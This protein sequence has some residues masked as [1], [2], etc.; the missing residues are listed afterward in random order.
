MTVFRW[1]LLRHPVDPAFR[2]MAFPAHRHL[3]D[4]RTAPLHLDEP[5][6]PA[7]RPFAV[8][9][10]AGTE[11]VGLALAAVRDTDRR[12]AELLSLY[13]AASQRRRGLGRALLERVERVAAARGVARFQA[14]WMT[15]RAQ[16]DA[17]ERLLACRGWPAPAPRMVSVRFT[18]DDLARVPWLTRHRLRR[19]LEI[20]PWAELT[21]TERE[22][23]VASQR[24]SSWI[25][26]DLQPWD[27]DQR[28]FDEVTSLG[29][30][31]EGDVVAWIINHS[32]S[33]STLRITCSYIRGDL[34]R[35]GCIVPLWAES[36][37]RLPLT[38]YSRCSF[39]TPLYHRGMIAFV[40]RWCGPW[41]SF[42]GETRGS[43]KLL[44]DPT[45]TD[46]PHPSEV[47]DLAGCTGRALEGTGDARA[48]VPHHTAE[49]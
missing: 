42:I 36:F 38:P 44:G 19:G 12:S 16:T 30:R 35:R 49:R 21:T 14:V 26:R 18:V 20:F 40:T 33:A 5:A 13:V 15:G 11:P 34:G 37:R 24:Q 22:H 45:S 17:V 1:E 48:R 4:L 31:F 8:G 6:A 47:E 23:L 9:T 3:L 10:F 7:V 28:G 2:P 46:L 43:T 39:T 29:M 32:V 27:Y 25:P 41:V